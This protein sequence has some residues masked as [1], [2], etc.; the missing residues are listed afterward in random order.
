MI[1][2]LLQNLFKSNYESLEAADLKDFLKANPKAQLI[3]VRG[4]DESRAAGT[5]PGAKVAP[6]SSPT[7]EQMAQSLDK[8]QPTLVF[9]RSGMRSRSGCQFLAKQGFTKLYN[10]NGGHMAYQRVHG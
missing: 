1:Q 8:N 4:V 2:S 3:D 5:I 10:L 6:L 7:L 9:C